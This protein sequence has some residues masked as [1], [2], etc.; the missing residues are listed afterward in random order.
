MV[1][2]EGGGLGQGAA[3]FRH[4][5]VPEGRRSL[6]EAAAFLKDHARAPEAAR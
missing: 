2:Q 5:F 6:S 3:S 1:L 4:S